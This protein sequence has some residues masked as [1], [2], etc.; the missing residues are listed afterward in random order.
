MMK[1]ELK[2]FA[3]VCAGLM[4][5]LTNKI[6]ST[7]G[8][9]NFS[10]Q[11]LKSGAIALK[12]V[13]Y[14]IHIGKNPQ[15]ELNLERT[16]GE[17]KDLGADIIGLQEV[18]RFSPR[19]G[20]IDQ[21]KKIAEELRMEYRF[22]PALKIGPFEYGNLMLSRYPIETDKRIELKSEKENRVG[23]LA[24]LNIH[25][26]KIGVLVTHLGLNV[27]ERVVHVKQLDQEL[28][29]LGIPLIVMGDFNTTPD[30]EELGPWSQHLRHVS[31]AHLVTFPGA[32][33]Q[34]DSIL[35]SK[36]FSVGNVVAIQSDASDHYPL[37][38]A[39]VL[40]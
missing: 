23:L 21:A 26:K 29:A 16:I 40:K 22:A 36:E 38:A 6:A 12:V 13:T 11:D 10:S 20:L 1:R 2:K 5:L 7:E 35:V 33:K 28:K 39:L 34:I 15:G 8:E 14:N 9:G 37:T 25:G 27:E 31:Q 32:Q 3:L 19:S 18:E 17:L 30:G 24:T 4:V